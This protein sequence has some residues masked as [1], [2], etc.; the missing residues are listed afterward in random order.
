MSKV[1]YSRSAPLYRLCFSALYKMYNF[2]L[3]IDSKKYHNDAIEKFIRDHPVTMVDNDGKKNYN[4]GLLS[5][6]I[7]FFFNLS[8]FTKKNNINIHNLSTALPVSTKLLGLVLNNNN[9]TIFS[10]WFANMR[11]E[12]RS[13]QKKMIGTSIGEIVDQIIDEFSLLISQFS[14]E[15]KFYPIDKIYFDALMLNKL[16]S[17]LSNVI[18]L[19]KTFGGIVWPTTILINNKTEYVDNIRFD[20]P[21]ARPVITQKKRIRDNIHETENDILTPVPK[22]MC[23]Y[24][25][26]PH[27]NKEVLGSKPLF[28]YHNIMLERERQEKE[29]QKKEQQEKER[30][31][32]ERL[33][34][35]R[36]ELLDKERLEKEK[37]ELLE[38]ELQ[39][40]RDFVPVIGRKS[41]F[42]TAYKLGFNFEAKSFSD[43][44]NIIEKFIKGI[45]DRNK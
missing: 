6:I 45:T 28:G 31:E 37:H 18:L 34:K 12:N 30:Q 17:F 40:P 35:E 10:K 38:K 2:G 11:I 7:F 39:E 16:E 1:S 14:S 42:D 9:L 8:N 36:Q 22:K 5:K 24:H 13:F 27:I 15:I 3:L 43:Q 29:R 21:T 41:V 23:A 44:N 25:S 19:R 4:D 33:E 20:T 32:K 26:N